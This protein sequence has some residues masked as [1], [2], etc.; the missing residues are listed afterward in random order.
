MCGCKE[1][2]GEQCSKIID[3]DSAVEFQE[4]CK[5]IGKRNET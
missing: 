5:E 2:H 4:H 3:M 1:F